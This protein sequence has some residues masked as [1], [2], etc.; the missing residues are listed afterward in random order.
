ML[1]IFADD[2]NYETGTLYACVKIA[3]GSFVEAATYTIKAREFLPGHSFLL[4]EDFAE[5]FSLMPKKSFIAV[6]D[7]PELDYDYEDRRFEIKIS[8]ISP[9]KN[10]LLYGR[11]CKME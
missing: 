8:H 1:N 2:R 10:I 6:Y 9:Q 11:L 7:V 5:S 4:L 3:P